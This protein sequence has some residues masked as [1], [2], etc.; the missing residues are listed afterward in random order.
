MG[1]HTDSMANALGHA[2]RQARQADAEATARRRNDAAAE[3]HA[4]KQAAPVHQPFWF[5]EFLEDSIPLRS[6]TFPAS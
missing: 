4:R 2:V 1:L 3:W 6:R 5:I